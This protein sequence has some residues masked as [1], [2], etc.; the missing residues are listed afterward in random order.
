MNIGDFFCSREM[1]LPKNRTSDYFKDYLSKIFDL[2]N[3]SVN[4]LDSN[5]HLSCRIRGQLNPITKL[6]EKICS[7]VENYL[8][9][10]PE[11]AYVQLKNGIVFVEKKLN[12]LKSLNV[13]S[14]DISNM[15]RMR[16]SEDGRPF[17]KPKDLFHIP[18]ELR[19]KVSS[20]RYSIPGLPCL[21]LG[22]SIHVCWH[23]LRQTDYDNLYVSKF[24]SK[25]K[26]K[27]MDFA[28]KPNLLAFIASNTSNNPPAEDFIVNYAVC[29]PLIA[30][31]SIIRLYPDS[32][33]APEHIIPQIIMQ[34]L[35]RDAIDCDGIR[36][37]STRWLPEKKYDSPENTSNY[38]FPVRTNAKTGC[39]VV[40]K[41]KFE[42]SKPLA[43]ASTDSDFSDIHQKLCKEKYHGI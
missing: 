13:Y 38:V 7:S 10:Q 9:G 1:E 22:S 14:A 28:Y 19:H 3:K 21:Y 23:E 26:I 4:R 32:P 15:Y 31:C 30:A 25:N 2:Y 35:M 43:I 36:Y 39:C 42:L 41:R 33:F 29:W 40:L 27:F 17:A 24:K 34:W 8:K 18:F 20:Q 12:N 37:F 6:E 11:K 16:I 5:C